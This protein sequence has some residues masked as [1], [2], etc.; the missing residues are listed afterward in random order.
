MPLNC[1]YSGKKAC[2][3]Q[4][5]K[6]LGT[7]LLA[8]ILW[9]FLLPAAQGGQVNL[10][11]QTYGEFSSRA[12][13]HIDKPSVFDDNPAEVDHNE[14]SVISPGK[15]V[16]K[17][18]GNT[19]FSRLAGYDFFV[20]PLIS[21]VNS[22][23]YLR[24]Q[25]SKFQMTSL[26]GAGSG[27]SDTAFGLS[28]PQQVAGN[29][30]RA[31]L[32]PN[33]LAEDAPQVI[34]FSA[35]SG[36]NIFT[37]TSGALTW[38]SECVR[39]ELPTESP[40]QQYLRC[41]TPETTQTSLEVR[42]WFEQSGE[43]WLLHA[44]PDSSARLQ[45]TPSLLASSSLEDQEAASRSMLRFLQETSKRAREIEQTAARKWKIFYDRL[46]KEDELSR[47]LQD[48]KKRQQEKQEQLL[49]W[50]YSTEAKVNNI[51][52]FH[53]RGLSDS[54]STNRISEDDNS[55]NTRE[56]VSLPA[57]AR[58]Y[59]VSGDKK[60]T[61]QGG[62]AAAGRS[63]NASGHKRH[64]GTP[65]SR[66]KPDSN[67][68][69]KKQRPD[70]ALSGP[71][72]PEQEKTTH[73]DTDKV[74]I[75]DL[76]DEIWALIF[77]YTTVRETR[78]L[79]NTCQRFRA[80]GFIRDVQR[81]Q[82]RNLHPE[83]KV[84]AMATT[85]MPLM[86]KRLKEILVR[87]FGP[88]F[89]DYL[90]AM[91]HAIVR[92]H[93][94]VP[95]VCTHT[96]TGH[97]DWVRCIRLLPDGRVLSGSD[98]MT[99][100]VWDLEKPDGEQCTHILT[101]HTSWV[102]CIGVLPDGRVLSGSDD[103]TIKVWDLEK[104]DGEQCTH[105][106]TGHTGSV[107]CMGALPDGRVLSGSSDKSIK[108]WDLEKPDGEQCTHTLTG[109][110]G[111]V[112][113]IGV[114]PDGRV[115]SGSFDKTIKVWDLEK[116]DGEQCTHT[117]TEHTRW[118]ECIGVLPDGRVLSGSGDDTIKV[119]DLE[120][121][122]GEQCTHTLTGHTCWVRCI[123]V[124]PDGRVLSGSHESIKVWDLEKPDGEQ[125][126]HTLTGHTGWVDCIGFLPDGRVL[127][128]SIDMTMKVWDYPEP[129]LPDSSNQQ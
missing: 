128:S 66:E 126:T 123:R 64:R 53:W 8:F 60:H 31:G 65:D 57:K 102:R 85:A 55:H 30:P 56:P 17:S 2:F 91:Q 79:H 34:I 122:D 74:L 51:Y 82:V 21:L 84:A 5:R 46:S 105:T 47:K 29:S 120:K 76:P 109:H 1:F 98:D 100:K 89:T 108:V 68:S 9:L 127:S 28:S 62:T 7:R 24:M 111:M 121:P 86:N 106:L 69:P 118:I 80:I 117:L 27:V 4:K 10:L 113:C 43:Q 25:E 14:H 3:R 77:K 54:G 104:P 33:L 13:S 125:C 101:G 44:F 94:F 41:D 67:S 119:W 15:T 38:H 42:L 96:L 83:S 23:L 87:R 115:L 99:I 45:A 63:G 49:Q 75:P 73:S 81:C 129:A 16:G 58:V 61:E 71:N 116:P 37:D 97:T 70:T 18:A 92:L 40:F 103:G 19:F 95:T 32:N 20:S 88:C 48:K 50:T 112:E 90:P 72:Q 39:H 26:P 12:F 124:L 78:P 11:P 110:T 6:N 93:Q 114:L 22:L 35:Q 36:L 107:R 59:Q 52:A